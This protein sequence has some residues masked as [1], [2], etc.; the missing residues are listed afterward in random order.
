MIVHMRA[1]FREAQNL[2]RLHQNARPE[3][4]NPIVD[5]LHDMFQRAQ[6]PLAEQ[7]NP[8]RRLLEA[9]NVLSYDDDDYTEEF[10][11]M[12]P[13]D[14]MY[15]IRDMRFMFEQAEPLFNRD[16]PEQT[17]RDLENLYEQSLLEA[18]Y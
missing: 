6:A 4:E 16:N 17:L 13:G 14:A 5:E 12:D 9:Q 11:A 3:R 8:I 10:W 2:M 1:M 15:V 7:G 18:D